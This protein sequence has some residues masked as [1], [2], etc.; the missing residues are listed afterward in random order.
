MDK[1]AAANA[2]EAFLRALGRDPA[3]EPDLAGTGERV[4]SAYA[5]ELCSGYAVDVGALL[6]GSTV[7]TEAKATEVVVLRDVAVTTMCPHHLM[8]ASGLATVAFAPRGKLVGLGTL[9]AVVDAYTRRLTLQETIGERVVAALVEHLSPHWAGCRL[10]LS[11]SCLTAR[12][13]RKHGA[14]A[15]TLALAPHELDADTRA[16]ALRALGPGGIG[17]VPQGVGE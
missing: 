1:P 9:A 15:E 11:H 3:R 12:G 8:P 13:E 2:I 5:D 4:A 6:A 10:V 17:G 16:L 14:R 7:Q